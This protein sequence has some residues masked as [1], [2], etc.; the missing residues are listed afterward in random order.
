MTNYSWDFVS[1]KQN[2]IIKKNVYNIYI[3]IY[4]YIFKFNQYRFTIRGYSN[5]A[6]ILSFN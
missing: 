2:K 4:I 3:Y 6:M 1:L 5:T